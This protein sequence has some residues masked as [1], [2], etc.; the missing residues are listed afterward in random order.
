MKFSK[1]SGMAAGLA[2]AAVM[3]S[4]GI[5]SAANKMPSGNLNLQVTGYEV[6]TPSGGVA[7]QYTVNGLGQVIG[8][9]GGS[10]SGG[11]TYTLVDVHLATEEVCNDTVTGTITPPVGGFASS[12]GSFT[13]SLALVA[14]S[15]ATADCEGATVSL[16][17]NRTLLHQL[18]VNDLD[19]GIYH[20]IA[21]SVTPSS[22]GTTLV[23]ASSLDVTIDSVKG[24]NA[25][26]N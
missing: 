25:P 21:T 16:L 3:A 5:A 6:L 20:C 7:G 9:M 17:C 23:D 4:A 14:G 24:A 10:L 12:D 1:G 11:L 18:D 8:D 13:A 22:G 15:G 2:L 26:N 19:A